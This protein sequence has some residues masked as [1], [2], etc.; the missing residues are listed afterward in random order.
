MHSHRAGFVK[1]SIETIIQVVL[2]IDV[3]FP[4]VKMYHAFYV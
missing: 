1:D 3:F 4:R 2:F